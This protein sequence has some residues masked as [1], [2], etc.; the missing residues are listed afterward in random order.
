MVEGQLKYKAIVTDAYRGNPLR[1]DTSVTGF[2]R[3]SIDG[4]FNIDRDFA[5]STLF[6]HE[7]CAKKNHEEGGAQW[8][9]KNPTQ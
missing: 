8:R 3:F 4:S 7:N 1:A 6:F 5:F 2:N 9:R